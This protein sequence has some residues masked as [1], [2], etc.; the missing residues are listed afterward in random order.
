[1]SRITLKSS[2]VLLLA[3]VVSSASLLSA[4]SDDE[5]QSPASNGGSS[6]KAGSAGKGGGSAGKTGS[7]SAGKPSTDAGSDAG[8]AAGSDEPGEGGAAGAPSEPESVYALT[9]QVFGETEN[10]SYVLLT[11]TI[12][13]KT[14]LSLDHAVV[15][16]AGR[17]LGTGPEGSGALFVA[18]DL[19]PTI[20]RYDLN[21][22]GNDLSGGNTVSFLGKGI[23]SFGEYG[24]QFQYASA[25][26]AYWFDG[27]TAQI[28]VWNPS[29]MKVTGSVS[30]AS[31]ARAEE[32]LSFTAAPIWKGDKLYTFAAWR[33]G[34]A[35][36]PQL[37]VVVLDTR[38]DTATIVEDTR[39]GYVRDGV[40][41]DDGQLYVATEAFGSAAEYLNVANP[42][43]CLLRFD[44]TKNEFDATFKVELASLFDGQSA[45]T[46]VV[47]PGNQ[48][49][50][51]VLDE[52]A[53]P[54]DVTNP[55]VLASAAAWGWAK[56]TPGDEPKVEVLEDAQLG[57]G[58]VLPFA[59]G[60]RL[61]APL[62]VAGAETRFIELTADGPST[63]DVITIPGLVFSAV[64]LK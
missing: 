31:L 35:I 38:K 21:E 1:M 53:I 46:L 42:K 59:L 18:G 8:G 10:Q 60:D 39:C 4:C 40:L 41:E 44:T 15:E 16:I 56:L 9:T 64:K 14:S 36:T 25:E 50:L 7:G 37:A 47:G 13:S 29:T 19:G 45:G 11:K 5:V 6:G 26:K 28:V 20:T 43:P 48:A 49:F 34:L 3:G 52:S 32:T 27:P 12:D 58:S 61:F 17:A 24:G 63:D 54:A 30:L 22:A 2:G 23:K 33:K 51:R 62:F 55:R 57:G